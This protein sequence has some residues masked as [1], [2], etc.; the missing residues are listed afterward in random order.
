MYCRVEVT[1]VD[2]V[3]I[4]VPLI[5]L[6]KQISAKSWTFIKGQPGDSKAIFGLTP[7][8]TYFVCAPIVRGSEA[9]S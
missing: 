1:L 9:W 4:R 6:R 5:A 8:T 3:V 2:H 7:S